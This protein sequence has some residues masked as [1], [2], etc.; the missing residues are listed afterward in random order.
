MPCRINAIGFRCFISAYLASIDNF[1]VLGTCCFLRCLDKVM[2]ERLCHAICVRTSATRTSMQRITALLTSCRH[3]FCYI[4]MSERFRFVSAVFYTAPCTCI[5]GS[6]FL[7]SCC[8]YR[9]HHIVVT[10]GCRLVITVTITTFRAGIYCVSSFRTCCL[11][12]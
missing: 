7:C 12:D 5:D 6:A 1:S 10:K 4:G 2:T 8:R 11:Y 3:C 9:F